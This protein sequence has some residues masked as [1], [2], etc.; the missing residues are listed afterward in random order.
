MFRAHYSIPVIKSRLT[1]YSIILRQ[2]LRLTSELGKFSVELLFICS[3]LSDFL[4]SSL[5]DVVEILS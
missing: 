4:H 3:Q 5:V 2:I 1:L